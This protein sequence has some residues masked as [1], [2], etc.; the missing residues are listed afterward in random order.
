MIIILYIWTLS[1]LKTDWIAKHVLF[2]TGFATS[3]IERVLRNH[4][5][6][7][8]STVPM[9]HSASGLSLLPDDLSMG[10]REKKRHAA[11]ASRHRDNDPF[12]E[13]PA[14]QGRKEKLNVLAG[15]LLVAERATLA[16]EGY[17]HHDT[18]AIDFTI[19]KVVEERER[20][21]N[22]QRRHDLCAE[23]RLAL[24]R[25]IPVLYTPPPRL[26]PPAAVAHSAFCT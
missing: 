21:L 5:S 17:H 8:I 3:W 7:L 16:Q 12:Y 13:A 20:G 15:A 4:I 25:I 11:A 10:A 2:P 23:T 22:S 9:D 14:I 24:V 18:F 19:C 26:T 6:N 1:G